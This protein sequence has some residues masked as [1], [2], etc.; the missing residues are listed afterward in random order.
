M[1]IEEY[2]ASF[3]KF[4]E[5]PTLDA[6][7]YIMEKF[8]NPHK[9]IKCVH[10]AGT[11]GK[12]SVCEMLTNVLI[13]SGYKVGKF[14]SPHLVRYNDGICINNIEITDETATEML[15]EMKLVIDEYN[16]KNEVPVK[17]FEA[18]TCLVYI[19]FERQNVDIAVIEAG[20]GGTMDCTNIIDPLVS[21]L[22]NIG[23]DH[24]DILGDSI[25]EI[26]ANEAGIVKENSDTVAIYEQDI[27]MNIIKKICKEKSNNLHIVRKE[28]IS[29]YS[30]Q[31]DFQVFDY[32]GYKDI[33]INLKGRFQTLN[34]T[35]VLETINILKDKGF[36]IQ[37]DAIYAG[38]STVIHKAR[39]EVLCKDPL[40]IFDGAHN[41]D[42]ICVLKESIDLHYKN[43]A[44]KIFIISIINTK[45]YRTMIKNLC[46][47][48]NAIYIFTNGIDENMYVKNDE[49][50]AEATKYISEHN[51]L[52]KE[53]EDAIRFAKE[54]HENQLIFIAGSFYVYRRTLEILRVA[55]L[56]IKLILY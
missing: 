9:K 51:I 53:L 5:N 54:E 23:Y 12:G 14:V 56:E 15:T 55:K 8:D 34:A 6:L 7:E 13:Y 45:D 47:D 22:T 16:D 19:Y 39:Q 41:E 29:N 30:T 26:A 4:T 38:L 50:C 48:K 49:L 27:T 46:T 18:I 25:E 44:K 1:N 11:N 2:F 24:M 17:W 52:A 28:D 35:E 36:D 3:D 43:Y 32:K 10:V 37:N 20:L 31:D 40:I 21:V 42:A 33:K